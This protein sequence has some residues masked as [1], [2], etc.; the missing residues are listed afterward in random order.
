MNALII[1]QGVKNHCV[2]RI[3]ACLENRGVLLITKTNVYKCY[4]HVIQASLYPQYELIDNINQFMEEESMSLV[5]DMWDHKVN[6]L[7]GQDVDTLLLSVLSSFINNMK[8]PKHLIVDCFSELNKPVKK[9]ITEIQNK[10]DH[11]GVNTYIYIHPEQERYSDLLI[12]NAD[13][14]YIPKIDLD[15]K[16][17]ILSILSKN[18]INK[19]SG[20]KSNQVIHKIKNKEHFND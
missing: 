5:F 10:A 14:F 15:I 7:S 17:N 6:E 8:S 19:L 16:S 20:L 2:E 3:N 1:K 18:E 9:R 13:N 4:D 11:Y 12:M